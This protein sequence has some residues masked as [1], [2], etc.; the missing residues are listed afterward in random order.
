M[1][2]KVKPYFTPQGVVIKDAVRYMGCTFE[3]NTRWS[4]IA[5]V[6]ITLNTEIKNKSKISNNRGKDVFCNKKK[7]GDIIAK[8]FRHFLF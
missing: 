4:G 1:N 3:S 7:K 6:F 5:V 8:T 2:K